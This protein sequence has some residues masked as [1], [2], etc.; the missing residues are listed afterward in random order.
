LAGLGEIWPTSEQVVE[1]MGGSEAEHAV[2]LTSFL[3][4]LGRTAY[5]LLGRQSC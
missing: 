4:G 1:M 5:L 3:L 2:L